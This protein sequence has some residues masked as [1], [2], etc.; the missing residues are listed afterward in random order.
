M[1]I[2]VT[3][4]TRAH[5]HTQAHT[6]NTR[7][8]INCAFANTSARAHIAQ[9][10]VLCASAQCRHMDLRTNAR[11]RAHTNELVHLDATDG[12]GGGGIPAFVCHC[13]AIVRTGETL[14]LSFK[15]TTTTMTTNG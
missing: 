2:A 9:S 1:S 13:D 14:Q 7:Y 6:Q 4:H 8:I 11:T 3:T 12:G 5:A 10:C 15:P